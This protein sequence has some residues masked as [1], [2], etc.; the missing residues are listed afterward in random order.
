MYLRRKVERLADS[1]VEAGVSVGSGSGTAGF[2][3]STKLAGPARPARV[4]YALGFLQEYLEPQTAKELQAQ[5]GVSV[6]QSATE[7][8]HRPPSAAR[9]DSPPKRSSGAP[10]EDYSIG[11]KA[12]PKKVNKMSSAAKALAKVDKK[13]MKSIA[14]MFGS[15]KKK[16]PGKK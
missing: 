5:M 3:K 12:P 16:K 13:G 15:M 7:A 1:L 14:S 4:A 8:K 10:T 2:S 9:K 11:A 6:A